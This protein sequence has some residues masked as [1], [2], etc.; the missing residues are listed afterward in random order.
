MVLSLV[1]IA[2]NIAL[3]HVLAN[4][5]LRPPLQHLLQRLG[6]QMPNIA[7]GDVTDLIV[8]LRVTPG[9]PFPV[10]NY[11]LGLAAVPFLRYLILSCAIAFPLNAAIIFFGKAL[12]QGRGRMAVVGLLLVL[13]LMAGLHLVRRRVQRTAKPGG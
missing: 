4:R 9:L 8:L 2:V 12:L 13:A 5:V 6:Y 7:T 11:L 10:Q 3:C 1:A